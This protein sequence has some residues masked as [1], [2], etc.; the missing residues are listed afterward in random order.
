M[1]SVSSRQRSDLKLWMLAQ[2]LIQMFFSSIPQESYDSSAQ[3]QETKHC[4]HHGVGYHGAA[5][6]IREILVWCHWLS[7]PQ[8][9][10]DQQI[11][12]RS[13]LTLQPAG[14]HSCRWTPPINVDTKHSMRCQPSQITAEP[15][16]QTTA[17]QTN[18]EP[19]EHGALIENKRTMK[20]PRNRTW[21]PHRS[22]R[23][24]NPHRKKQMMEPSQN[25]NMEPFQTPGEHGIL[26]EPGEHGTWRCCWSLSVCLQ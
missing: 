26:T 18:R 12:L 7:L 11:H 13:P 22:R 20:P 21:K 9:G 5:E 10:I 17:A 2:L 6:D 15:H 14:V 25:Y 3:Q 16:N 24:W 23:T 19:G 1:I 4:R 8:M